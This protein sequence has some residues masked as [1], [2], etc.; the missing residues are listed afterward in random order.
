M[1]RQFTDHVHS[2]EPLMQAVLDIHNAQVSFQILR[3]RFGVCRLGYL[4]RV[5]PP[6]CITHGAQ[7][8]GSLLESAMRM[9]AGG[10]RHSTI[11]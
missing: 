5:V 1:E 4:L 7:Y 11:F 2:L 8:F 9:L 10:V 6:S 3:H